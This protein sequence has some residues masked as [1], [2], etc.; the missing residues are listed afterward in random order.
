MKNTITKIFIALFLVGTTTISAQNKTTTSSVIKVE[1]KASNTDKELKE[2]VQL[3]KKE[4][5]NLKFKKI[6][7]NNRGEIIGISSSYKGPNGFKGNYSFSGP[8]PI[9]PF[10]FSVQYDDDIISG[11]SYEKSK[12]EDIIALHTVKDK[13]KD[14]R[15]R[16][17]QNDGTATPLF[18][19]DGKETHNLIA[20]NIDPNNIKSVSVLKNSSAINKYGEKGKNGVILVSTKN[21]SKTD[22]PLFII[23]EKIMTDDFDLEGM[24]NDKIKSVNIYKDTDLMTKKYGEKAKNG[25]VKITMKKDNIITLIGTE[26]PNNIKPLFVIDGKQMPH[27]YSPE[28]LKPDAIESMS[29]L[30]GKSATEIYGEKAKNGV[31][32]IK[33]K[34]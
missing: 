9:K 27:Y 7:R 14:V 1:I 13:G 30:K 3:F 22:A 26:D 16:I 19:V 24:D 8:V 4:N 10:S 31:I 21:E 15:F 12:Q 20:M 17:K 28:G 34:K 29:V 18:I 11:I 25:V 6:E 33:L 5:I 23:D 32:V 2:M